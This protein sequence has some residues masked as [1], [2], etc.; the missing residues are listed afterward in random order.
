[1]SFTN[2]PVTRTLVLGL[3]AASIAASLF[4][5]KH[6]FYISV[7]THIWQYHQP[8]RALIYQLCY[9]NSSEVLFAAMTLYN[10]RSIE[11]LWGSRKYASFIVVTS[12]LTAIIPPVLLALVIR[13]L[14][15]GTVDYLPAGPTPIIF[16][17]LAQYHAMV[18]HAYKYKVALS[19]A[20]PTNNDSTG[21]TFSDK[22]TRYLMAF[23]LALLQLPG[24]LLGAL[25]GWITGYA[26]RNELLPGSLTRWRVPGWVVGLRNQKTNEGFEGIRRRLEGESSSTGTTSGIQQPSE[27]E[28]NRRRTMGE[29][30]LQEV[31]GAF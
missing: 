4:D 27:G 9:T 22:S 11:Q 17:L 2:A 24:S 6:Y 25:V 26:W 31:R 1:M 30:L 3:V 14:S 19:T 10:L 8:W 21:L 16:A 28:V 20:A 23:Q 29:Q 12:L 18:P 15:F 5:V 13:P 7:G